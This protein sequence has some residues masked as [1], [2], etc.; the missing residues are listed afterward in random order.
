[1]I[2]KNIDS[3]NNPL[4]KKCW[5]IYCSNF[6]LTERRDLIEQKQIF[7]TYSS[8]NINSSNSEYIFLALLKK[9]T[10]KDTNFIIVDNVPCV[11]VGILTY[12]NFSEVIYVEHL[13]INQIVQGM[14]IGKIAVDYLKEC[15]QIKYNNKPLLLEIELPNNFMTK[16]R[17]SFYKKLD[18]KVNDHEH[19]QPCFHKG[20]EP[21]EMQI[22]TWPTIVSSETYSTFKKEQDN[23]MPHFH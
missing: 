3:V 10:E 6:P 20:D 23:M 4:F 21:L 18:F 22:M 16:R 14:G 13:A 7:K 12:W 2:Y 11:L 1:M 17:E 8:G 15:T 9:C 19:F 5:D